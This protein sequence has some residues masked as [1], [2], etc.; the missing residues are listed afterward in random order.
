MGTGR[1]REQEMS[2]GPGL[3][4]NPPASVTQG[5][6]GEISALEKDAG[7]PKT[8]CHKLARR[9]RHDPYSWKA[10]LKRSLTCRGRCFSITSPVRLYK[11]RQGAY[12]HKND[13]LATQA[14]VPCMR[15][16]HCVWAAFL[17]LFVT[18]YLWTQWNQGSRKSCSKT[19][20]SWW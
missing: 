18:G 6:A 7:V 13:F 1:E 12:S 2:S 4:S 5:N 19:C 17:A 8:V 16:I 20:K 15:S 14:I 11:V 3:I 9:L 10:L